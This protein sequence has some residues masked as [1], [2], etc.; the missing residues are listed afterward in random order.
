MFEQYYENFK[1]ETNCLNDMLVRFMKDNQGNHFFVDEL[2][3]TCPING[4][5]GVEFF[6]PDLTHLT[7]NY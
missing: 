1:L 3:V 5:K 2:P 4:V 6:G 7:G